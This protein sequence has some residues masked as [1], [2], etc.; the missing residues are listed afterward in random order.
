VIQKCAKTPNVPGHGA[1]A[2][3]NWYGGKFC[4]MFCKEGY[5]VSPGRDFAEMLT[6]GD[7]G[8]WLPKTALP[9]PDCSSIYLLT[10][11]CFIILRYTFCRS[12]VVIH[13]INDAL[14]Y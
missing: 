4:Q 10:I 11:H 2:C 14:S 6:C 13:Y 3:D 7:S 8:D 1:L 5:D 12:D 9:L